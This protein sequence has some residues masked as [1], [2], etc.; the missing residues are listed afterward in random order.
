MDDCNLIQRLLAKDEQALREFYRIYTPDVLRYVRHKITDPHEADDIFQETL[1]AFLEAIRDFHG[2]ARI[3][4]FLFS[5]CRHKIIDHYR[6]KKIIHAV[7]SRSPELE[8][9][10]SPLMGPEESL[11]V[12][13][14]KEKIKDTFAVLL[15][16]YRYML[17]LRYIVNMPVMEIAKKL[18][19]TIK[20]A[21]SV[22]TRAKKAFVKAYER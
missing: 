15:P 21:E 4:T 22:L 6:K 10:I 18:A 9:I 16:Q 2:D 5:I 3:R 7:F 19:V 12:E 1:Y 13:L 17:Y 11:D 8:E 14:V 20:S